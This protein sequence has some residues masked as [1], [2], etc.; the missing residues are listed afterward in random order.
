M[1]K[2]VL[3]T[4][5]GGFIGAHCLEYF[6]EK[7]DWEIVGLDS[8]RHMGQ[9][10][11]V[12][13]LSNDRVSFFTHD[14]S[15]PIDP[16]LE[17]SLL[18]RR[19]VDDKLIER[20]FDY[21]INM[22]A[23]SA[24]EES[25]KN[26]TRCLRNNFELA[27]NMLEFAR[28]NPCERFI[29]ISTDEVYGEAETGTPG[30]KEWDVILPSNP[31]AASK[32]AQ[33]AVAIA[34][35]RTYGIP[36]ILTNTMN[37]IGERQHHEKFL[38]KIIKKIALGE[39]MPI[40]ADKRGDDWRIGSRVYLDAKN[41]ADALIFILKQPVAMYKKGLGDKRP[42]RYNICGEDELNNLE[43]AQ[44]VAEL[45]GKTLSYELVASE[46]MRPGY[47]RRYALDGSKL[48]ALGWKAPFEL[49]QTLDRI[50]QFTIKSHNWL[51]G[52]EER[53]EEAKPIS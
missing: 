31:Y 6:L 22:A 33:E 5:I 14:L 42:D 35:W 29:Q 25:A 46:S 50:I 8:W 41:K 2:R 32:A 11:R 36:V 4:G 13:H 39:K 20:K 37:I 15:V 18:D 40:Y 51:L 48:A 12:Q 45:M 44:L 49:R 43:L 47:D 24:V 27:V 1:S 17:N 7:T 53:F 26:P 3:L 9:I 23:D 38:P 19:L 16:A 30:H 34:Y 21:I 10:S 52:P 28:R